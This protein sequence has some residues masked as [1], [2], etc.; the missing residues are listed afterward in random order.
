MAKVAGQCQKLWRAFAATYARSSAINPPDIIQAVREGD[1]A[2]IRRV[3]LEPQRVAA[4]LI[5]TEADIHSLSSEL[6]FIRGLLEHKVWPLVEALSQRG[7]KF[8]VQDIN[9]KTPLHHAAQQGEVDTVKRLIG[10]GLDPN[11]KDFNE[12]TPLHVASKAGH[13]EIVQILCRAQGNVHATDVKR[14]TP[15][16]YSV[17]NKQLACIS[18]LLNQGAKPTLL[19]EEGNSPLHYAAS[20]GDSNLFELLVEKTE[21]VD[22]PDGKGRTTLEMIF[23]QSPAHA[24]HFH[25]ATLLIKRGS[26]I[27][28][29]RR[30][31]LI[32]LMLQAMEHGHTGF[33][34]ELVARKAVDI[35]ERG[36][37]GA[38]L[39]H[40]VVQRR[41]DNIPP[42]TLDLVKK[43]INLGANVK[44]QDN[45]GCT[46]LHYANNVIDAKILLQH[47]ATLEAK[48]SS[49]ITP[50]FKA[51]TAHNFEVCQFLI[52]QG[53]DPYRMIDQTCIMHYVKPY[54]DKIFSHQLKKKINFSE[55][56]KQK[57][58][59]ILE[60]FISQC[61]AEAKRMQK[62]LII[63][64]GEAHG[65]YRGYQIEKLILQ[66]ANHL[67]ISNLLLEE[68]NGTVN[69]YENYMPRQYSEKHLKFKMIGID[70][71]QSRGM[72][73]DCTDHGML[74]R[75]F[76]MCE[77]ID[78][79]SEHAVIINGA[80][81]LYG[82]LEAPGTQINRSKTFVLPFNV[83][84]FIA[85][86]DSVECRYMKNPEEIIQ[87]SADGFDIKQMIEIVKKQNNLRHFS[88]LV[89]VSPR[90]ASQGPRI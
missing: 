64:I 21:H 17:V 72:T 37:Q 36:S 20:Q 15:L 27:Q 5:K 48:N 51:A 35:N 59:A 41:S 33:V 54:R 22:F 71:N 1:M 2:K 43:L 89:D 81:H 75:N 80:A 11:H 25:I 88:V 90:S 44:A 87:V 9:G 30:N 61:L 56:F 31:N 70:N 46:P 10:L 39:L 28:P 74:Y 50:L 4:E 53:A 18:V 82:L 67:N 63:L 78:D 83:S 47:G 7:M 29:L 69:K 66:V 23:S 8:L 32:N 68:K 49:K 60:A 79:F 24:I 40:Q 77:F 34:E 6:Q 14:R 58:R 19:D 65:E 57:Q 45:Y 26:S 52:D 12:L 62:K 38:T 42:G 55:I 16:H 13:Q 86:D 3:M 85:M 73:F 84:S 76:G